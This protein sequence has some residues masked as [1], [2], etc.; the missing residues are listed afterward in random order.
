MKKI[1]E[2][3]LNEI[4]IERERQ[5]RMWGGPAHDDAHVSHDWVAYITKH[6]GRAVHFPWTPEM[7]KRQMILI[8]ALAVAAIEWAD[9]PTSIGSKPHDHAHP[10]E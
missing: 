5:D 10:T 8:A 7:F 3:I 4:A 1:K 9:R 2:S 6:L